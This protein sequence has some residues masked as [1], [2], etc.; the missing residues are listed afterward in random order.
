MPLF[1][2]TLEASRGFDRITAV[3]DLFDLFVRDLFSLEGTLNSFPLTRQVLK[4]NTDKRINYR[5]VEDRSD[6]FCQMTM[7]ARKTVCY[8]LGKR[9]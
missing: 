8:E 9:I 2:P 6:A 5:H 4:A 3:I 7:L 1:P